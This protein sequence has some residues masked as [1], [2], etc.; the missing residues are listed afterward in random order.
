MRCARFTLFLKASCTP[1]TC[2]SSVFHPHKCLPF[3]LSFHTSASIDEI[4]TEEMQ[5]Q[6]AKDIIGERSLR[7][8]TPELAL[9]PRI[10]LN[11][12]TG[13]EHELSDRSREAR[14]E[15]IEWIVAP[16]DTIRKLQHPDDDQKRQK[17]V[18][19][20]HPLRRGVDVA[21]V[22]PLHDGGRVLRRLAR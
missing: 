16:N 11:P 15:G 22:Y 18:E 10:G 13:R 1:H 12:Q 3:P 19:Q 6:T 14:E 4:D 7:T 8:D 2:P 9:I 5:D 21:V 20:L 17:G